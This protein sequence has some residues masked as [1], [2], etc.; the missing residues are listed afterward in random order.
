MMEI[1]GADNISVELRYRILN[2]DDWHDLQIP[3][4][5]YFDLTC[6]KDG[7]TLDVDSVPK[8]LFPMDYFHHIDQYL[9]QIY[10]G[11]SNRKDHTKLEFFQ[12]FYN[13]EH[14]L[15]SERIDTDAAGNIEREFMVAS[16]LPDELV[17][18][19]GDV[20]ELVRF[21]VYDDKQG[22]EV[23]HHSFTSDNP[24]GSQSDLWLK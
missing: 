10:V 5:D 12:T 9:H 2:E 18:H 13:Q 23:F 15:V 24:D 3:V 8:Y 20:Y 7:E 14:N 19:D 11:I 22:I 4:L 21:R 16:L 6:L 1:K 17:N